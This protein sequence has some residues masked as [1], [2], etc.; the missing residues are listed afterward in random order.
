MIP[1]ATGWFDTLIM[2]VCALGAYTCR[3]PL[4]FFQPVACTL[5]LKHVIRSPD[6]RAPR[7]E[8]RIRE[9]MATGVVNRPPSP[10]G[11]C[12]FITGT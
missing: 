2:M 9:G 10:P 8:P 6:A 12:S 1:L 5:R 4:A 11:V 3:Q 7:L